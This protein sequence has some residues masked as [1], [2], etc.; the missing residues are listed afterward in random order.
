M[1]ENICCSSISTIKVVEEKFSEKWKIWANSEARMPKSK[2]IISVYCK[3]K[4]G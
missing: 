1:P 3:M 4:L 2:K